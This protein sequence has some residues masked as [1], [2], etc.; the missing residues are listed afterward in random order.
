[1]ALTTLAAGS[2]IGSAHAQRAFSPAWFADKGAIQNTASQTGR[3]P[4]GM[5]ASS[6]TS[7]VFDS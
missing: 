2:V 4:N 7:V 6:L 5:P 1:M 3:L